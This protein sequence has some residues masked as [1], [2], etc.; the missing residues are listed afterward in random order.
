MS[1]R[2]LQRIAYGNVEEIKSQSGE[3]AKMNH[4]RS[5]DDNLTF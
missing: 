5:E 1:G 2:E 4:A 3:S